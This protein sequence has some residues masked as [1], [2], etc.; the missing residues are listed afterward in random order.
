MLERTVRIDVRIKGYGDERDVNG[1]K[2][3]KKKRGE[4]LSGRNNKHER[5][6]QEIMKEES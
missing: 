1:R 4:K 2:E 6:R 5:V 3:E